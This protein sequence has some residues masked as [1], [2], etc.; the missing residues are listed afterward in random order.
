MPGL[1]TVLIADDQARFRGAVRNLLVAAGYRVLEAADGLQALATCRHE[2]PDVAVLDMVMPHL[3]GIGVCRAL[4]SDPSVPYVPILFYSQ[5]TGIADRVAALRAGGDDFVPK[6]VDDEELLARIEALVRVRRLLDSRRR[7]GEQSERGAPEPSPLPGPEAV[8]PALIRAFQRSVLATEPL[9]MLIA[10]IGDGDRKHERRA[11]AALSVASR[12]DDLVC[13]SGEAEYTVLLPSTH[14]GGAMAAAERVWQALPPS[15][16]FPGL[17]IGGACSPNPEV[18][19]ALD[20][21]RFARAALDRS[22]QE[23]PAYV[24]L[25]HH[26]AYLFRPGG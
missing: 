8:E 20:L 1:V 26:Q 18:A 4:R 25:Y 17:S 13:R 14:F 16:S 12:G 24:C 2:R 7:A 9:S 6:D 5:R 10:A 11:E 22:R 3:D 23:G 19:D 15:A 21:A